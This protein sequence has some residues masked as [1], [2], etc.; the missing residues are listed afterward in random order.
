[1][2]IA[3]QGTHS[4]PFVVKE[5]RFQFHRRQDAQVGALRLVLIPV[6]FTCQPFTEARSISIDVAF[7]EQHNVRFDGSNDSQ[8]FFSP[9]VDI[10]AAVQDV[11]D[12]HAKIHFNRRV[13]VDESR[14]LGFL[15]ENQ[16]AQSENESGED[17]VGT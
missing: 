17:H 15:E 3:Q 5:G 9:L 1:M 4:M 6:E 2:R 7:L 8:G 14:L 10:V 13:R 11:P 16:R 12:Q